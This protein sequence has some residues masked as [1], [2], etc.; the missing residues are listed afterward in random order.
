MLYVRGELPDLNEEIG[1]G[2]VGTRKSSMNSMIT[3]ATLSYRI[4][5]AGAIVIS[6]GA[7]GIDT[8]CSQGALFAKKPSIIV[9]PCGV[10]YDYLSSLKDVRK[11]VEDCGAVISEVQPLGRV[12]RDAFQIRNRIIAALSM[13]IVAIEVPEKSGV[14]I[15]VGYALEYGKDIFAIPGDISDEN[16]RGSNRLLQDG[17]IPVYTP[18]DILNE[19][20]FSYSHKLNINYAC[21][22]INDDDIY[23][24]LHKKYSKKVDDNQ[25][26]KS[27]KVNNKKSIV[28]IVKEKLTKEQI[29]EEKIIEKRKFEDLNIGDDENLKLVYNCFKNEPI[30][31][32]YIS[33]ITGIDAAEVMFNLTELEIND[34]ITSLPG[35]RFE[36]K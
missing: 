25:P 23:Y 26:I 5:Q 29:K 17:A 16:Y 18:A 15:T 13:G 12:E 35:G 21:A 27:K 14:L 32:D 24:R 31:A 3:A 36:I 33:E 6:G 7:N 9:R 1:I 8:K 11:Q 10:N 30:S 34:V 19:Y 4:A 20:M 28:K 2:M 22:A